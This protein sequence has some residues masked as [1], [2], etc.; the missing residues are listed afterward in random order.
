MLITPGPLVIIP[1]NEDAL[2]L[3]EATRQLG[4]SVATVWRRR[5]KEGDFTKGNAAAMAHVS[6]LYN[7][8]VALS[9]VTTAK[10]AGELKKRAKAQLAKIEEAAK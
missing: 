9:E 5:T 7:L 8:A 6:E 2:W 10:E 1:N 3:K 4:P